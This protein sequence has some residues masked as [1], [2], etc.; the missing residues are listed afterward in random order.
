MR[1]TEELMAAGGWNRSSLTGNRLV[2]DYINN[3]L[4]G[5]TGALFQ[6]QLGVQNRTFHRD[7]LSRLMAAIGRRIAGK[8][9]SDTKRAASVRSQNE[10]KD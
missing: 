5:D 3:E 1:Y 6:C 8:T 7:T 9:V 2:M 10:T 4:K